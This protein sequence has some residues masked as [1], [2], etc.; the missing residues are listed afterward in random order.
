MTYRV[1]MIS[2]PNERSFPAYELDGTFETREAA[3]AAATRE[4]A[5]RSYEP[6][7]GFQIFNAEGEMVL[8]VPLVAAADPVPSAGKPRK[9]RAA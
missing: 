8:A 4:L 2:F 6:S 7:A 3:V 9:R 1:V 5:S